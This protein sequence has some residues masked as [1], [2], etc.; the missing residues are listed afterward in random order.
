MCS[1]QSGI[2]HRGVIAGTD[3][4]VAASSASGVGG[5]VV[6]AVGREDASEDVDRV[7]KVV[8]YG[9]DADEVGVL[10]A[11]DGDVE[12]ATRGGGCGEGDRAGAG[13][14]WVP[15]SVAA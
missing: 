1:N 8:G 3:G 9:H 4:V 7:G 5:G 15:G 2:S 11:C 10:Y 12:P 14:D 13:S 6:G